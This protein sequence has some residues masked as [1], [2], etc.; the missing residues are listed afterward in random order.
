MDKYEDIIKNLIEMKLVGGET[1][2][3]PQNY[4]MMDKAIDMGVSGQMR[5]VITTNATL[6]P[7][8]GKYGDIFDYVPHFKTCQMNISIE[9]WGEKNNYIRFPSKWELIM[10]NVKRFAEMPRTRIL[11]ATCVSSLNIGYL[12]EV[13]DGVD[14]LQEERPDVYNDFATGSLV[15]GGDNLYIV[16]AIPLDIREQYLDKIYSV[17]KPHHT[18]TFMKLTSYLT[19]MKWD[20]ELHNKMMIDVE[21]RDKYRGTC[22]TDVFPEWKPYYGKL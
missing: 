15:I 19:D 16:T 5:L 21:R 10:K 12:N 17:V 6:T 2:A 13:A 4:D 7:K 1:L 3:L 18:Q 20:E 8:M 22:L 11:F 9:C 14:I